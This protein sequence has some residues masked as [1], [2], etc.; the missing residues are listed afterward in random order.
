ML[1]PRRARRTGCHMSGV[2]G[3]VHQWKT[4]LGARPTIPSGTRPTTKSD[5]LTFESQHEDNLSYSP[6]SPTSSWRWPC[7]PGKDKLFFED[8]EQNISDFVMKITPIFW[9]IISK[10][11]EQIGSFDNPLN[12]SKVKNECASLKFNMY[13]LQCDHS[14]SLF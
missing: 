9:I 3:D 10:E 6:S 14:Q 7:A 8:K 1:V 4:S 2:A 12:H 13:P 5:I 11:K